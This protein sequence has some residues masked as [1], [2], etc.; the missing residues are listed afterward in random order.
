MCQ[1]NPQKLFS[2]ANFLSIYVSI[3]LS[4][5]LSIYLWRFKYRC[6]K[7]NGLLK[8][9]RKESCP[10]LGEKQAPPSPP[11]TLHT[12]FLSNSYLATSSAQAFLQPPNHFYCQ[13]VSPPSWHAHN[14]W[15]LQL[16]YELPPPSHLLD[17]CFLHPSTVS[18][19][20]AFPFAADRQNLTNQRSL[21]K[22]EIVSACK[23]QFTSMSEDGGS[24]TFINQRKPY[25]SKG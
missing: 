15:T 7:E 12:T 11:H 18:S 8:H 17:L 1:I 25:Y 3:C 23:V 13:T 4:I 24:L 6:A 22:I 14:K 10:H 2:F 9:F 5:Y 16:D 21:N 19:P 20:M